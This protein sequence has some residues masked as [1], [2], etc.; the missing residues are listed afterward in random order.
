MTFEAK[1]EENS[2]F[3]HTV[4]SGSAWS[5]CNAASHSRDPFRL[6]CHFIIYF[7][8]VLYK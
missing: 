1:L 3:L 2:F 4:S 7:I 5:I 8:F 6:F